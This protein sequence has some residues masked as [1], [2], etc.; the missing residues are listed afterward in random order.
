MKRVVVTGL[1]FTSSIGNNR[2]DVLE[3][4]RECRSG[5]EVMPELVA[6]NDRVCLAGTVK[7]FTF[8]TT[9]PLDWTMPP[10]VKL[11][12]VELRTMSPNSVYAVAAMEEAIR[13]A[14]LDK[15]LISNVGTGIHTASGGSPWLEHSVVES[16]MTRGPM[17]TSAPSIVAAMPNGLQ[18]N[19]SAHYA[20]KGAALGF[21]SACASSAHALGFAADLIRVGRQEIMFVVGAEDL[22]PS[23]ILAFASLRALSSQTDPSLAPRAFARAAIDRGH[24]RPWLAA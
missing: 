4:L 21:S 13:D 23:C 8:P 1:G 3:S 18:L 11:N 16:L 15:A 14:N 6:A 20:I 19:L 9:D 10:S 12:R 7:G 22:Y 24:R 17:R 5:I 2:A